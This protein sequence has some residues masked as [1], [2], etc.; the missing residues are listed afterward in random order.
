MIE[1]IKTTLDRKYSELMLAAKIPG[2]A[3]HI[4]LETN[5]EKPEYVESSRIPVLGVIF[6]PLINCPTA[7]TIKNQPVWYPRFNDGYSHLNG[8]EKPIIIQNFS[9]RGD[10]RT[11][12]AC[13]LAFGITFSFDRY[14]AEAKLMPTGVQ[15]SC[16]PVLPST[17]F[18]RVCVQVKRND[19]NTEGILLSSCTD[20]A[21]GRKRFAKWVIASVSRL[22]TQHVCRAVSHKHRLLRIMQSIHD[23]KKDFDITMKSL[24]RYFSARFPNRTLHYTFENI[25]TKRGLFTSLDRLSTGYPSYDYF[26]AH[27]EVHFCLDLK[28]Q[29][30]MTISAGRKDSIRS[31]SNLRV[32]TASLSS[33][34]SCIWINKRIRANMQENCFFSEDDPLVDGAIATGKVR[35]QLVLVQKETPA[36]EPG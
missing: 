18:A 29:F 14:Y 20:S 34:P 26:V 25:F 2:D 15:S 10:I 1:I 23:A 6:R 21:R 35:K 17:D 9:S 24:A 12:Q 3:T 33:R 8:G 30:W 36:E 11:L 7:E 4:P 32:S 16:D 22:L 13:L 27:Q 31:A 5:K 19:S 28:R